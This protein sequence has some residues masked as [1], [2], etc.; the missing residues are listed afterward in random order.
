MTFING[1]WTGSLPPNHPRGWKACPWTWD[2]LNL[3]G[4]E[5]WQLLQAVMFAE[6]RNAQTPVSGAAYPL[7]AARS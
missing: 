7:A 3:M 6:G 4:R 1:A 2:F 5:G